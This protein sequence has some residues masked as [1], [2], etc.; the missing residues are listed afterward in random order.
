MSSRRVKNTW[1]LLDEVNEKPSWGECYAVHAVDLRFADVPR[2]AMESEWDDF[3]P[4]EKDPVDP[5]DDGWWFSHPSS[6]VDLLPSPSASFSSPASPWS[7]PHRA[8]WPW[9]RQRRSRGAAAS[10][11]YKARGHHRFRAP[12]SRFRRGGCHDYRRRTHRPRGYK[13][14]VT[15]WEHLPAVI[16]PTKWYQ[17]VGS[18]Q[19]SHCSGQGRHQMT[20]WMCQ[21][22]QVPLCLMPYR[23]CYAKWHGQR[24]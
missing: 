16:Q 6:H 19:C 5:N 7:P 4:E 11:P 17:V 20:S 14:N 1:V 9:S 12:V 24:C 8:P 18:M 22:C 3:S 23:N 10:R 15:S 2:S 13:P 21:S